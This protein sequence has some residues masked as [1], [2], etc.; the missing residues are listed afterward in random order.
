MIITS[1]SPL[2]ELIVILNTLRDAVDQ[3][4]DKKKRL[5]QYYVIWQ[6]G[7]PLQIRDD[8]LQMLIGA[9]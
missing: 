4:L 8:A 6:D 5:W 9:M 3:N 2:P 7:R 1:S